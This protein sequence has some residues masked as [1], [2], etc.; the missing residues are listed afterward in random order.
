MSSRVSAVITAV[1]VAVV[2]LVIVVGAFYVKAQNYTPFVPP[3]QHTS[4]TPTGLRQSLFSWL[5][6]A[7]GSTY[8]WYGL[9]A[10]AS[11]V[12]FAFIGFDIVATAAEE[13]RNPQKAL[14]RAII[15]SLAI[16]TV[17][18]VAVTIVLTGMVKYTDLKDGTLATAFELNGVTW[19][20]AVINI[21]ALAGL[22][23]VI[24]VLTLGQ[25]RVLFAMSRDRLLP[26]VLSRTNHRGVPTRTTY[27]IGVIVASLAA[28]FPM[29][30]LEEMVNIGT[31]FAF[32]LVSGGVVMLRKTRPELTRGF[33]V[34]LVPLIPI[35]SI[36]ACLWLMINLSIETWLRFV[37]WMAA[38]IAVYFSYGYR[39]STLRAQPDTGIEIQVA[40]PVAG[41]SELA[42]QS[43]AV[44]AAP[45]GDTSKSGNA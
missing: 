43:V 12:F 25:C 18:Y 34:P 14:P 23:T 7:D 30:I 42:G 16:V 6:G 38:G 2:V 13:T 4:D 1:K 36:C 3:A 45:T 29:G 26:P 8:G 37:L 39:R 21:G 44:E 40:E 31:L 20:Q 33:R 15:G 32:V 27:S 28:F 11:L 5:T 22:T 19:A 10:A 35:A 41:E 24:I 17:L 9:L